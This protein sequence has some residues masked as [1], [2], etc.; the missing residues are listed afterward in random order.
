MK[1]FLILGILCWSAGLNAVEVPTSDGDLP[2]NAYEVETWRLVD[3]QWVPDGMGPNPSCALSRLWASGAVDG[4]CNKKQWVIPVQIH[5]SIAQWIKFSLTGT[6]W[7]WRV[8]KPGTYAGDCVT[9]IVCS[10][11]DVGVDYDGFDDLY[12]PNACEQ[13]IDTWYGYG[14]SIYDVDRIG[15]VRAPDLNNE[16]DIIPEQCPG[17]CFT[18]KLWTKIQVDSCNTAC[19]Y[20]DDATVTLVLR[21]QKTWVDDDGSWWDLAPCRP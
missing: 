5:A 10:N 2:P 11:G 20:H 13:T 4:Q 15:W 8:M 19:E 6:R 3:G 1:L 12:S 17:H 18:T 14:A 21:N 16:D 7:D 9:F